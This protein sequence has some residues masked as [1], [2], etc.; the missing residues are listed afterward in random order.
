MRDGDQ[1]KRLVLDFRLMLS[2]TSAHDY[3]SGMSKLLWR[4]LPYA[5]VVLTV[6]KL[7]LGH[8]EFD[9]PHVHVESAPVQPTPALL[10][11]RWGLWRLMTSADRR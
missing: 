10:P 4:I 3:N 7:A 1:G 9:S 2:T 8:D 11:L 5:A 6:G